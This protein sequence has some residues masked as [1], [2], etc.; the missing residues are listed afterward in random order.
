MSDSETSKIVFHLLLVVF[1]LLT[2][3]YLFNS[4]RY[5]GLQ[6]TTWD[7]YHLHTYYFLRA[8]FSGRLT[9]L[10]REDLK[11]ATT[12]L[13]LAQHCDLFYS[14]LEVLSNKSC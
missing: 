1:T 8:N 7:T 13:A 11:I 10:L 2:I 9:C 3:T 12:C 4:I 6:V 14:L 5:L